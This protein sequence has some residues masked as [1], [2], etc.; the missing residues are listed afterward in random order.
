MSGTTNAAA[1]QSEQEGVFPQPLGDRFGWENITRTVAR[2]YEDLPARERSRA[3]IFTS[4]YGEASALNFLGEPYHLPPAIS[5]HNSYYLWG[6]GSCTG[7][8]MITVG[9]PRK[10]VKMGFAGVRRAATITRR[11]CMPEEDGVPVYVATKPRAPIG[12][13]WPETKHYE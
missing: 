10:E 9:I 6:P 7:E 3:C 5:G 12:R 4:N 1:G 8:V 11:Y 2:V 13:L